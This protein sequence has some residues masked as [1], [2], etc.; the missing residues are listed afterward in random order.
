MSNTVRLQRSS[1]FVLGVAGRDGKPFVAN[2]CNL[3]E[4]ALHGG[5]VTRSGPARR[6]GGRGGG[7]AGGRRPR[8]RGHGPDVAILASGSLTLL[9]LALAA[10]TVFKAFVSSYFSSLSFG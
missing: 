7:D 6:D 4:C 9:G 8:S 2:L 1:A 5:A 3:V 10:W